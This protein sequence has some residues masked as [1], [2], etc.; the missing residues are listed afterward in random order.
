[1]FVYKSLSK[2]FVTLINENIL[3]KC[4]CCKIFIDDLP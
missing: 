3:T 4:V 2:N 1:M